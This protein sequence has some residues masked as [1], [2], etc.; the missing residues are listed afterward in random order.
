MICSAVTD[1][2]YILK[3]F[4]A[5][6]GSKTQTV[7]IINETEMFSENGTEDAEVCCRGRLKGDQIDL[8]W[9]IKIDR[10]KRF[11]PLLIQT[12]KIDDTFGKIKM[13]DTARITIVKSGK[14]DRPHEFTIYLS[15]GSIKGNSR[16]GIQAIP[17]VL[18][19][20]NP[21][22]LKEPNLYKLSFSIPIKEFKRMISSF[23][24]LKSKKDTVTI[25]FYA[26][27]TEEYGQIGSGL[28]I[29][30][31]SGVEGS[32]TI[33]ENCGEITSE[34]I[35]TTHNKLIESAQS[36]TD[37]TTLN[38]TKVRPNEYTIQTNKMQILL[39]FSSIHD[40]GNVIVYYQPG[41]HLCIT[42]E[43]G[44]FGTIKLYFYNTFIS[45]L[46]NPL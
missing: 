27:T 38:K 20:Y 30:N 4:M 34:D 10:D 37:I 2:G 43:I 18:T 3:S 29:A 9:N 5:I 13:K 14:E 44:C 28:T 46:L 16:E 22:I 7:I 39:K 32:S 40:E 6:N 25:I 15:C 35:Q 36:S 21:I 41:C 45:S 31:N 11:L 17:A 8:K 26:K 19:T 33:V 1:N 23:T 12:D 24:K 42:G